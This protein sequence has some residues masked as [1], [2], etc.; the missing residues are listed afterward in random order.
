VI[1]WSATVGFGTVLLAV[2]AV[3]DRR[4]D[5]LGHRLRRSR[6]IERDIGDSMWD[7]RAA[8]DGGTTG[9]GDRSWMTFFERR[10]RRAQRR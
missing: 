6:D 4:A 8:H 2:A 1:F 7:A 5:R 3:I 10:Y 9:T